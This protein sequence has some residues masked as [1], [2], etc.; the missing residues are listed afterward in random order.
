[1]PGMIADLDG[2]QDIPATSGDR[3]GEDRPDW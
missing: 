1:L 3:D 2:G